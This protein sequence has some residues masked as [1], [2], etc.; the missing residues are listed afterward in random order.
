MSETADDNSKVLK[1]KFVEGEGDHVLR[2]IQVDDEKNNLRLC[3]S[4]RDLVSSVVFGGSIAFEIKP[5]EVLKYFDQ[6]TTVD[7]FYERSE[8]IRKAVIDMLKG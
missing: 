2:L 7:Q 4:V 8:R 1:E 6:I 3:L 5:D